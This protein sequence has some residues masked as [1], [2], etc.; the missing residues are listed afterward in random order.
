VRS[1][2]HARNVPHANY[3]DPGKWLIFTDRSEIDDTWEIVKRGIKDGQLGD[4]AKVST[5]KPS[6]FAAGGKHVICVYTGNSSDMECVARVAYWLIAMIARAD[7]IQYK[8]DRATRTGIYDWNYP[9][10]IYKYT[11]CRKDVDGKSLDE[12]VR[13]FGKNGVNAGYDENDMRAWSRKMVAAGFR[14]AQIPFLHRNADNT[15]TCKG[16]G[17]Y[18]PFG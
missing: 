16:T 18:S 9:G 7:L 8:A 5:A 6:E 10:V 13:R 12:F 11:A 17:R 3:A 15:Y 14:P 1:W 4:E 2:L